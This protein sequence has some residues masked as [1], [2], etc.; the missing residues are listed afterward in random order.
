LKERSLTSDPR[1]ITAEDSTLFDEPLKEMTMKM[2]YALCAIGLAAL[3][4]PAFAAS[5]FYVV[6]DTAT[7]KCSVVEQKPTAATTKL[8]G[9]TVYK[10]QAEADIGMKADKICAS[11]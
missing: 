4:T 1:L 7:N 8:V 9:T 3:V 11:K 10:T 6:Q 2:K 5:E